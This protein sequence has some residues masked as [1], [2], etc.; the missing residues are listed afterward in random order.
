M[1]WTLHGAFGA[2]SDWDGLRVKGLNLRTPRLWDDV[3]DLTSWAERFAA[4]VRAEDPSPSLMG[5]SLGGRLAL[6]ALLAAPRLWTSAVIVS[7]HPGIEDGTERDER[8]RA[9]RR[10]AALV[11]GEGLDEALAR[12]EDQ[13][14]FA[15]GGRKH[16]DRTHLEKYREGVAAGFEKWSLGRQA[17]LW[18]RLGQVACPVLWVTGERDGKFTRLGARA[19]AALRGW[20]HA[21]MAGCGH[22]VPWEDPDG[23]AREVLRFENE[24]AMGGDSR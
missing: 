22:R 8:A 18:E 9:D 13:A 6:H 20:R 3:D 12:W 15:G 5:Y 10:W 2:P 16:H 17:P 23:F 24:V 14:L 7:A 21:V 1:I 4:R 11:R 19:T